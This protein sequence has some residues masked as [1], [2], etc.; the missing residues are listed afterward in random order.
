MAKRRN[1]EP[2]HGRR[3]RVEEFESRILLSA[4]LPG[5][6]LLD[7]LSSQREDEIS[8]IVEPLT[9]SSSTS[10]PAVVQNAAT[11]EVVFVDGGIDDYESLV[12]DLLEN[13]RTS[14][15]AG[16]SIE[17]VVL[18]SDRDGISQIADVLSR[19]A[20]ESGEPTNALSAVHIVSHGTDAGIQ[21]GGTWLTNESLGSRASDVALWRNSLSEN[22]DLLLYGCNLAGSHEGK[23]LVEELAAL[24]GADVAA[25]VDTTGATTLGGDWDFEH[26]TG[27]VETEVAFSLE[28]QAAFGSVL[29]GS[30]IWA[31]KL[32]G[33]PQ[34][35]AFD[36]VSFAAEIDSAVVGTWEVIVGAEAPTRDEKIVAGIDAAGTLSVQIWDGAS[37][38]A[39]NGIATG[40][41]TE[42]HTFDVAYST[43][44]GD[45]LFVY[46]DGAGGSLAFTT[47][48]G[49]SWSTPS[50]FGVPIAGSDFAIELASDPNSNEIAVAMNPAGGSNSVAIWDGSSF[51]AGKTFAP[52]GPDTDAAEISIVYEQ[53]SSNL[54]VVF[55][56]EKE[57]A[58]YQYWDGATWTSGIIAA[59]S[60]GL[61]EVR[62][63]T[64]A[65]DPNSDQIVF[66]GETRDDNVWLSS[67]DGTSWQPS[68]LA[69]TDSSDASQASI[70]VAFESVSGRAIAT[71]ATTDS[72]LRYRS[73]QSGAGWG[74]EQI[75]PDLGDRISSL[76]LDADPTSNKVML[77]LVE[78]GRGI[79]FVVWSGSDWGA[80]NP[81]ETDA[82]TANGQPFLFLWDGE[83][84]APNVAP[85][86]TP[87]A[88]TLPGITEDETT[89]LGEQVSTLLAGS[90]SDADGLAT[91]AGIAIGKLADGN[92]SWEYSL[93]GGAVWTAI[94]PVS[95][96]GSLL[97]RDTDSVRFVPDGEGADSASFDFRAWDQSLG[98]AGTLANTTPSGGTSPFST[99]LG[100]ATI[101]VTEV[102]D[103]PVLTPSAPSLPAIDEDDV[104]NGGALVSTLIAGAVDIDDGDALGIAITTLDAGNGTWQFSTDA[105]VS[106]S[107]VS[108]V[109]EP[110]ALLLA[111]TDY[112]RFVPDGENAD[113]ASFDFRAWDQSAGSNG[114]RADTSSP[115]GISAFSLQQDTASIAVSAVNDAPVLTP[116]LPSL[117]A[118]NEDEV[119]NGGQ[120]VSTLLGSNGDVDAS[121]L[122]GIA[123]TSVSSV[124]WEYS[125]NDGTDWNAVGSVSQG[126]A[127]LLRDS[128]WI[129]FV[130][131][132][133]NGETA[134]FTFHAWDQSLG[135]AAG[136][137]TDASTVGDFTPFSAASDTASIVVADRNDA[138]ILTPSAPSLTGMGEDD[139]VGIGDLVSS[140]ISGTIGDVDG[141]GPFGI[142]ITSAVTPN[143]HFEYSIDGGSNWSPVGAV[144]DSTSLLLRGTDRV[145]F[146]PDGLNGGTASFDFLAWDQ[147]S[148]TAGGVADVSSPGGTTAF[149]VVRDTASIDIA[150]VNDTPTNTVPAAT[151]FMDEGTGL[152]FSESNGNPVS[153]SDPDAGDGPI[154]VTLTVTNGTLTLSKTLNDEFEINTSTVGDQHEADLAM[155]SS[156]NFV[157]VWASQGQDG[158]GPAEQ[159]VYARLYDEGG[160][161]LT[162]EILVNSTLADAQTKPTVAMHD[163]GSFVVV[164]ESGPV[165][166]DGPVGPRD[167]FAQRFDSA[168]LAVGP[169]LR[170]NTTVSGDQKEADVAMD[171]AGNFAVVWASLGQD[172]DTGTE[173][174]IYVRTYDVSGAPQSGEVRANSAVAGDQKKAAIAMDDDGDF[175]VVWETRGS[176]VFGQRFDAAA[177]A[178]GSNFSVSTSGD[179]HKEPSIAMDGDG[180]FVVAWTSDVHAGP[181]ARPNNVQ[182]RSFAANGAA[183]SGEIQVNTTDAGDQKN[184]TVAID[185]EGDFVVVW[186]GRGATDQDGIYA[187]QFDASGVAAGDEF[188]VNTETD[189]MQQR[190][191]VATYGEGDFVAVWQSEQQDGDM[192][193]VVGQRLL[194]Q[195]AIQFTAGDG[196]SDATMT[197][198]GRS[199]DI[200]H[201]LDG[202]LFNPTSDYNGPAELRI[203]T[204]DLG[205][206]GAGGPLFDD[207]TIDIFINAVNDSPILTPSSPTLTT[208]TENDVAND[209]H[210][211][212]SILGVLVDDIDSGAAEGMAITQLVETNGRW[213]YDTGA[214]WVDVGPVSTTSALLL[215]ASDSLRFLP[216]TQNGGVSRFDFQAWDQTSGAP[217]G[218]GDASTPGGESTFSLASDTVSIMV[219]S[220]NDAPTFTP[221]SPTLTEITENDIANTGDSVSTLFSAANDVDSGDLGGVAITAL[222]S[223]NGT[224]QYSVDNG[225][226][227]SAVPGD[228]AEA[229]A[230]LL[231]DNDLVRFVPDGQNADSASFDF[232][233]W[234]QTTGATGIQ[235]DASSSGGTTAFSAAFDTASITVTAVNDAPSF[236]PTSPTLT[237]IDEDDIANLGELVSTLLPG[238]S[239]NDAGDTTGI[240][241]TSLRAGNGAWQY[242]LDGGTIWSAVPTDVS[243]TTA[244]L[245]RSTDLVRFVPDGQNADAASFDFRA[246][247][248]SAGT[249]GTQADTSSP[250]GTSAFSLALDTAAIAVGGIND[251]PTLDNLGDMTLLDVAESDPNPAGDAVSAI[252]ASAGG[253]RISDFDTGAVEGIAVTG[254][255]DADGTWQY[256][257]DGSIWTHFGSVSDNAAVLLNPSARVRFVPD[258]GYVG[259]AGNLTFRA[260][261]QSAGTNAQTGV[262]VSVTGLDTPYSVNVETAALVVAAQNAAPVLTPSAPSLTPIHE[263]ETGNPGDGVSA[264]LGTSTSDTNVGA[265]K[266][267]A[268]IGLSSGNGTWQYSTNAGASWASV[269]GVS[270]TNALVLRDVDR[271]RFV[272]DALNADTASFDFRAWDQTTSAAGARVNAS[273]AGGMTAFSLASDTATIA[274][275]ARNDAPS[276]GNA[277]L[278]STSDRTDPPGHSVADLFGSTF[279]DVDTGGSFAG[280]AVV[281]NPADS[282]TEGVWQYSTNGG[283]NWFAIGSVG[284]DAS[285]LSLDVS[286]SVRFLAV[287]DHSGFPQSL[288]LRG[289]DDTYAGGF[290][291]TAGTETRAQL[292]AS[293]NGG[294]TWISAGTSLLS[295]N[296]GDIFIDPGLF[297]NDDDTNNNDP[298]PSEELDDSGEGSSTE[299][300]DDSSG[301]GPGAEVASTEGPPADSAPRGTRN[302]PGE[303]PTLVAIAD[304]EPTDSIFEISGADPLQRLRDARDDHDDATSMRTSLKELQ[305]LYRSQSNIDDAGFMRLIFKGQ[306]GVF[307]NDLD[308]AQDDMQALLDLQPRMATST[309][310]V[311]SGLS[312]GYVLWMTRGGLLV[313]SLLS[314]LPAWRLLDPIPVLAQLSLSDE[315]DEEEGESLDTIVGQIDP[316]DLGEVGEDDEDDETSDD[317]EDSITA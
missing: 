196:D 251:A 298:S 47:W 242:S 69:S 163:D 101:V 51:V 40:L 8:E 124:R 111:G 46:Q 291:S 59:P 184:P 300:E 143:G 11:R 98:A 43:T 281:A 258:V 230:L 139:A 270:D 175:V 152:P 74:N 273:A 188:L 12:E 67:W 108:P 260:W 212:A 131:D 293:N 195:E 172:G 26:R 292:D 239:D 14:E 274:V 35:S 316:E 306:R 161:P 155:A 113:A 268:V 232:R 275:A 104:A 312:V 288:V 150:A 15:R 82:G 269:G 302:P 90:V 53:Q 72:E 58:G 147:S 308:L 168:G 224:W 197:F 189:Q 83:A 61:G 145:R 310:A 167:V 170:V 285:A 62:W 55:G 16:R 179:H 117:T 68:V 87:G 66:A 50:S 264:I 226:S 123:M 177:V 265:Q 42:S 89:N 70:A 49:A 110:G 154:E 71:Y 91:P 162:A 257:T 235:V 77:S 236:I 164:W 30:A 315:K 297:D 219:T 248:R 215:R 211:V 10:A 165:G 102:N 303:I 157:I 203:Q 158:D 1:S 171:A 128:D 31:D 214:G 181:G 256:S 63:T 93:D 250:G 21:L 75:G 225:A 317:S 178:Q 166:P 121:S 253:D 64:I 130:P 282:S 192:K 106:W 254:V 88:L 119:N 134:N 133:E 279:A 36:G 287:S 185:S 135:A 2:G 246:W 229:N 44:S 240:A 169:E 56:N 252:L 261:D 262:D 136:T 23:A 103:A 296:I 138:P 198:T 96:A 81:L 24:T 182:V 57:S 115:G 173:H 180:N 305:S 13:T 307:L 22:A 99:A 174:N 255:N 277:S 271:L 48:D 92:G 18:D 37:W 28:A 20:E 187:R 127:L 222:S 299:D 301:S 140:L 144:T 141:A 244:L 27:S 76:T 33:A 314:S 309:A 216:D 205:S 25:S 201:A 32:S 276:L 29:D 129:R 213:Q 9:S 194:R 78:V 156:G 245:L 41:Q 109:S 206:T 311:T 207:D 54:M 120:L 272:P 208:I 220:V 247:D 280:V 266:G 19:Y 105:G 65:A 218:L 34:T 114:T 186:E 118:I 132:G 294:S 278:A 153:V 221:S 6:A 86:L 267:I 137:Q 199:E 149:S 290:S 100:Q 142:A 200:N 159:N 176:G 284:D 7:A 190:P 289:L 95:N 231:R 295:T 227:W 204:S 148:G 84:A 228:V 263:D 116:T 125:I 210:T 151:Q 39:Y 5:A 80:P 73:W 304:S 94:G 223:G 234:D 313:A 286:A 60:A 237:A 112:V 52:V 17:V 243:T 3:A 4:D 79:D 107:A 191:T 97:L 45:S 202:M 183:L 259:S 160:A 217:G 146:A 38:T 209:G 193:G 241:V 249:A 85:V 283:A 233:R 126:S 238:V 122:Q